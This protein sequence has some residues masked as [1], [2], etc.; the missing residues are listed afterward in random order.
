MA[1][2]ENKVSL[3]A[4][5][6]DAQS[7]WR[8]L[9][10]KWLVI[11]VAGIIG[12]TLGITFAT[13]RK[14]TYTGTTIFVLSGS[15]SGSGGLS[16]LAGQLG[17]DISPDNNNGAFEGDNIVVLLQSRNIVTGAMFATNP[18]NP[19]LLA[20]FIGEKLGFFRR[21]SARPYLKGAFPFPHDA[22]SLTPTQDSLVNVMRDYLLNHCLD[23]DKLDQKLTFYKVST[24]ATEERIAIELTRNMVDQAAKMYISTKTKTAKQNLDMLQHEADSIRNLLGGAISFS[25]SALDQTYNL[26]PALQKQRVPI[27]QGEIQAQ[28]LT[29]AYGEVLKNLELAKI[30]LQK[31]TPLYQ[32]V[33]EPRHPLFRKK[34]GWVRAGLVG[35]ALVGFFCAVWLV[36]RKTYRKVMD[37]K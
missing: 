31:E 34:L 13:I 20:N 18:E 30:D 21:W 10:S 26:N 36:G 24:T 4:L 3:K 16:A 25:A 7:W 33:D 14:P 23:I 37:A 11:L 32:I 28:V 12:L 9:W 27:Q 22:T 8:Y 19:E 5:I 6:L 15:A 1:G 17:V 29:L 2:N 35:G